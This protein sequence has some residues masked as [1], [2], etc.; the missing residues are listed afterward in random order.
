M[1]AQSEY[2]ALPPLPPV[3]NVDPEKYQGEFSAVVPDRF[4]AW[5]VGTHRI[6][7]DYACTMQ[8]QP[9]RVTG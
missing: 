6:R 9:R 3:A 5:T 7:C 2:A 1:P 4:N 8:G